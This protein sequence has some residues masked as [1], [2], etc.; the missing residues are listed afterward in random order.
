MR[1]ELKLKA[2]PTTQEFSPT[3]S[4]TFNDRVTD[5]IPTRHPGGGPDTDHA[6][7]HI[8]TRSTCP[9]LPFICHG[10]NSFSWEMAGVRD[11]TLFCIFSWVLRITKCLHW[12]RY[13][14]RRGRYFL[15]RLFTGP[16][17]VSAKESLEPFA[18]EGWSLDRSA[19]RRKVFL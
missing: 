10:C 17:A 16:S 19:S 1:H 12:S 8:P 2:L 11:S 15:S 4:Y 18:M 5:H 6:P 14:H 3:T 7:G 9:L 13:E